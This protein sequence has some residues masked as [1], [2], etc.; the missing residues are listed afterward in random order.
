MGRFKLFLLSLMA[1]VAAFLALIYWYQWSAKPLSSQEVET[2]IAKID[3]QT[4]IPGGQ[5]DMAELRR[6]LETDDGKPFYTVNLYDFYDTANY[7]ENSEFSGSGRDAY[8]R[9]SQVMVKLMTRR[10]S[11]P[12]Y[13]SYGAGATSSQWDQIVIVRYRSRRDLA[14]LF[15]TEDFANASA[16]KW[17]SLRNHDRLIV[18]ATHIPDGRYIFLILALLISFGSYVIFGRRDGRPA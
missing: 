3:A 16:H 7:F 14:D 9:F 15:A 12:I 5:H 6:F 1:G 8:D 10:G 4:Q 13:G 2:Y 17:A 11:H 18:Q